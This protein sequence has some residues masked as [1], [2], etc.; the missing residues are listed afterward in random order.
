MLFVCSKK[1][2]INILLFTAPSVWAYRI[3]FFIENRSVFLP[4]MTESR[5]TGWAVEESW[6]GFQTFKTVHWGNPISYVMR[7][8]DAFPGGRT[9][10]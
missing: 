7:S 8:E 10:S 1:I 9:C 3:L 5:Y 4:V 6:F 2:A